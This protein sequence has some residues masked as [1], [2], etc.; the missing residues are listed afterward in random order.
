MLADCWAGLTAAPDQGGGGGNQDAK[1]PG[2]ARTESA[3]E[4]ATSQKDGASVSGPQASADA[5]LSGSVQSRGSMDMNGKQADTG[6]SGTTG[7]GSAPSLTKQDSGR[8]KMRRKAWRERRGMAESGEKGPSAAG[9]PGGSTS[10]VAD[11]ERSLMVL[12]RLATNHE[13]VGAVLRG[14]LHHSPR[15]LRA[16]DD[17][18]LHLR[19]A[20]LLH[21]LLK[22]S[23][24][25]YV[26]WERSKR[27]ERAAGE[28]AVA[29][30]DGSAGGGR[31]VGESRAGGR[32]V[33]GGRGEGALRLSAALC[34]L[35]RACLGLIHGV[36]DL[37]YTAMVTI[38]RVVD[39]AILHRISHLRARAATALRHPCA[40]PLPTASPQTDTPAAA[41]PRRHATLPRNADRIPFQRH[42][43]YVP[44]FFRSPVRTSSMMAGG[45]MSGGVGRRLGSVWRGVAGDQLE[46]V[47]RTLTATASTAD[48]DNG[49][50]NNSVIPPPPD[51]EESVVD[52][53][54]SEHALS[55]LNILHNALTLYKRVVGSRQQ[56][57]P[58]MRWRHCSYHC[59][60][61][62][63]ARALLV[64]TEQS[65]TVQNTLAQEPQLRLLASA[66]DST[67]DPQLLVLVLQI[68]AALALD[69]ANHAALTDQGIP[70]ALSQL[71]LPSDEWYYTNHSTRYARYVKHHAARS[72]VYMGLQHRV[73]LRISVYDILA[74]DVPP[75]TPLTESVEDA[76]ISRTSAAPALFTSRATKKIVG[77]SVEGAV[78]HVLGA[79][80][81]SLGSGNTTT[82]ELSTLQWV[83]N[84][85]QSKGP[86]S[87]GPQLSRRQ[88]GEH[89]GA[90]GIRGPSLDGKRDA[91]DSLTD[92][93]IGEEG[94]RLARTFLSCFPTVLSPVVLLRLL[95]HRLLTTAAARLSRWKSC[96]SRSSLA[97]ARDPPLQQPR[98]PRSRASSADTAAA[99]SDFLVPSS[100]SSSASTAA[101]ALFTAAAETTNSL[102]KRR[103]VNLTVD[104]SGISDVSTSPTPQ[105]PQQQ[106][107][108]Q[109]QQQQQATP[110]GS[111]PTAISRG[112]GRALIDQR[113][114]V[115]A[116]GRS[117]PP[118]P[119]SSQQQRP[120]PPPPPTP[121]L[122]P[123][124]PGLP[125]A[126]DA[127]G[128]V[129]S[130]AL[131][132]AVPSA[133]APAPPLLAFSLRSPSR[134]SLASDH[135]RPPPGSP[136]SMHPLAL[137]GGP[138]S[139]SSLLRRC[140]FRFSSSLRKRRSKSH[141]N[142][143]P[144]AALREAAVAADGTP[145]QEIQAFQRQLQNLPDFDSPDRPDALSGT[146]E[147]YHAG[148]VHVR[149][150]SRSVPR[151]SFEGSRY[152]TLPDL[153]WGRGGGGGSLPRGRS[154]GVL[155]LDLAPAAPAAPATLQ[156]VPGGGLGAA[157]D[158]LGAAAAAAGGGGAGTAGAFGCISRRS[159]LSPS[160]RGGGGGGG[161]ARRRDSPA[162]NVL[163]TPPWHR[164]I[165]NMVEEWLRVS[166][167]ELH[168]NA[169]LLRELRDFLGKA[170]ACGPPYAQWVSEMRSQFPILV[171]DPDAEAADDGE[172]T[173]REY[174]RLRR[175]VVRGDL[176][177]TKEEAAALAG[178]QLRIEESWG[179][180]ARPPP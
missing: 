135:Y 142:I 44:S 53:L 50:A 176:A 7:V 107:Q 89:W 93:G 21:T 172:Q 69:P 157:G 76:Y 138:T 100:A 51:I 61:L 81:R 168:R 116:Q 120:L 154:T 9:E 114:S 19:L 47:R 108:Q 85:Q 28:V 177:C 86:P 15:L 84:S 71:L 125:S 70:D 139:P 147:F 45:V 133:A 112:R 58:S 166:R 60:Q 122:A 41:A 62:L 10:R 4:T 102:R 143:A 26:E 171:R 35:L 48:E 34:L 110:P 16:L 161:V 124:T 63:A 79:F 96:A 132:P 20:A 3:D 117:R 178:I 87:D 5:A 137:P 73:N 104:C 111:P 33:G 39:A 140:S 180:G 130:S 158:T 18:V 160:E 31:G 170:A 68:V 59:L 169:P 118:P 55:V 30:A 123:P 101:A 29:S 99:P 163:E 173:N 11:A 146:G 27:D 179:A 64:M 119:S 115:P 37:Q 149:P 8:R 32:E 165:L 23:V 14:L 80:E 153:P 88:S 129:S 141:A 36:H 52:V 128:L 57:S 2:R 98:S 162:I 121:V 67:H 6:S 46:Q 136:P 66:L 65:T 151:V 43:R 150:R 24:R 17:P 91:A 144:P 13:C 106:P 175:L 12:R 78:V 77:L 103:K 49:A 126:A 74:E 167:V 25:E 134:E 109:Q 155:S 90:P 22:T 145:E 72:L 40:S 127:L 164:A 156:P 113:N 148:R 159:S 56:C 94:E 38:N 152:L 174:M 97:S 105:Q 131:L 83:L 95:L 54:S 42:N 92:G 82:T 1:A 75:P